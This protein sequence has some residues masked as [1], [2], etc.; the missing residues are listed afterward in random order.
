MSSQ[1]PSNPEI[2]LHDSPTAS[3]ALI[4]ALNSHLPFS[5]PVLRRIQFAS[6]FPG[7]STPSTHIL[8]ASF[9]KND[10]GSTSTTTISTP[11]KVGEEEKDATT[12]RNHCAAAYLDLSRYPETQAW[13]YSTLED[14]HPDET[15]PFTP[16]R[17]PTEEEER[18]SDAL[19]MAILQ[20]MYEIS[21]RPQPHPSP[22][23]TGS[24]NG[25]ESGIQNARKPQ[26]KHTV[27]IGSL[28][29]TIRQRLLK[30]GVRMEKTKNIPPEV[31]WEFCNKW[32][33]WVEEL[34]DFAASLSI[35]GNGNG[36]GGGEGEDV[37][38]ELSLRQP[39]S[40]NSNNT[41]PGTSTG[42]GNV[43]GGE[44]EQST[45]IKIKF[46]KA[47]RQDIP[48]IRSRTSI[49]RKEETLLR[50]PSLVLRRVNQ[51]TN[52]GKEEEELIAWAFTALDGTLMTL[53]VEPPYRGSGLAKLIAS[54]IMRDHIRDYGPDGW[55]AADVFVQ[56][57]QSQG[58]CRSIGGTKWWT[59]SWAVVDLASV[60]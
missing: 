36:S 31:E 9:N 53:H 34:P 29:E 21:D 60:V 54:K 43:K 42:N 15:A 28:H 44:G 12:K 10:D 13:F 47:R 55:G 23:G 6:K 2:I 26:H 17:Q 49:D 18:Q 5:L 32:L 56:N 39:N 19:T 45:K 51:Q 41:G 27:L 7:G 52:P 24:K 11:G 25:N 40:G 14:F 8:Y 59:L 37:D 1:P 16:Q 35:N 48:L 46:D 38:M 58:V 57:T 3:P 4:E 50:L 22:A 33:F 30:M 20:R